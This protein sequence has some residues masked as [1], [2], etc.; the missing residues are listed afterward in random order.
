MTTHHGVS[1]AFLWAEARWKSR[2]GEV[3]VARVSS[4]EDGLWILVAENC[5]HLLP[6]F[7]CRSHCELDFG[8]P[9]Q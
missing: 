7:R 3:L 8:N 6:S 9:R 5:R 1:L 2:S 4:F